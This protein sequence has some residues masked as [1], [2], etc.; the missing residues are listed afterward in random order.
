MGK[1]EEL[2]RAVAERKMPPPDDP[3]VEAGCPFLW[4]MLTKERWAD[5]TERILPRVVIERIPGAYKVILQDDSLCIRK[6]TIAKTLQECPRALEKVLNDEDV[7]W[8][9]FKSYRN[10]GGPKVPEAKKG[11]RRR[12]T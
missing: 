4:E 9:S 8:E 12:S 7:P 2:A 3:E 1:L 6:E 5:D 11:G 10:K